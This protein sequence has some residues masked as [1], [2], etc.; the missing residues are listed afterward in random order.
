MKKSKFAHV[1]KTP[2]F[3]NLWM[4]QILVQLAY[5][6]LNF[7]LIIWVFRLTDSNTAVS[8]LMFAVYLP[9]VALSLFAGALVDITD[10]KKIILVI[11]ILLA[12]SFFSLILTKNHYILIL[13]TAFFINT[14]IQF[15]IPAESSA[16]PIIVRKKERLVANSLFSITLFSSFLVG[17]GLAGPLI[18]HLGIN[19][20]FIFGA[21][22]SFCAF[23][24]GFGFPYICNKEDAQGRRLSNALRKRDVLEMKKILLL[25]IRET[26]K[27][28]RQK[29]LLFVPIIILSGVQ[30]V[31]GILA[32]I[33]PSFFEKVLR[34]EA[35][36]ASYIL[37]I[38]LGLGMVFGGFLIGKMGH[39]FPRRLIA[40]RGILLAGLLFFT[41][42][43]APLVSPAIKYFAK[44][45]P[46]PF[47]YQPPLSSVL[48]LGSFLMG[49]AMVS[50]VVPTQ[51]VLQDN[52]PEQDR[53]KIF[54]ALGGAMASVTLLP[55]LFTGVLADVFGT[56]PIFIALGGSVAIAGLLALKPDFF[57]EKHH[58]SY[59][60]RAFLGRG[61][62]RKVKS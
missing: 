10:R 54:A 58:L 49:I 61:H 14:L 62:W 60:L 26:A 23:L 50:I 1:I 19:F 51:T 6:C 3:V 55:V 42:G 22:A 17:F 39:K 36:D 32:V 52:T 53:G 33:V 2:G 59:K 5:N 57:F 38:P 12:I 56:T 27:L 47:F 8:A 43:I 9:A 25:E 34:I 41:I 20:V 31:I 30:M 4:N 21:I 45:R 46:L 18:T 16:I 35:T 29:L 13:V 24:L 44:P 48:V 15:Y 28:I 37:V 40:G 11:N 7:A